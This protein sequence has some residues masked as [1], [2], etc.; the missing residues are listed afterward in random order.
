MTR[1]TE[2][3]RRRLRDGKIDAKQFFGIRINSATMLSDKELAAL[4][5]PFPKGEFWAADWSAK[6]LLSATEIRELLESFHLVGRKIW[7]VWTTSHDFCNEKDGLQSAVYTDLA[8]RLGFPDANAQAGSS[9]HALARR[10]KIR[11]RMEIDTPFVLEFD[12]RETFEIDVSM[13]PTY[14]MAM[15][16]IPLRILE[17]KFDNIDPMTM[18]SPVLDRTIAAVELRTMSEGGQD[19][20]VEAVLLR[21]DNGLTL[22]FRGFFDYLEV[23]LL[24]RNGKPKTASIQA[25]RKGFFNDEDLHFDPSTGFHAPNATL[26]FGW[27]GAKRLGQHAIVVTAELA[28][29]RGRTPPQA[30]IDRDDALGIVMGL[31][32]KHP[33]VF[34]TRDAVVLSAEEWNGALEI[35]KGLLSSPRLSQ[36][37][38]PLARLLFETPPPA[39][40]AP[41]YTATDKDRMQWKRERCQRCLSETI[42]WSRKAIPAAGKVRVVL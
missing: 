16:H 17:G 30:Y 15:N 1:R 36:N 23:E 5:D 26:W 31:C 9:I 4:N 13:A 7:N 28:N 24:D 22:E 6:T 38:T 25:L 35:G 33:E 39:N 3:L 10:A 40:P 12:T 29:A 18:F 2:H 8:D 21:L 14:R 20:T 27:K 19:D 32:A 41:W 34:A 37:E 42:R 11:R